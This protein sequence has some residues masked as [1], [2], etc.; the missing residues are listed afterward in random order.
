MSK[1]NPVAHAL[2]HPTRRRI[3]EAL[4]HSHGS[5]TAS[6]FHDD[7]MQ[8]ERVGLDQIIYHV[9]QLEKDGIVQF[10]DDQ[11]KGMQRRSFVLAGPHSS[12]AVRLL[13]LTPSKPH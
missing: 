8:D 2:N 5:L 11:D 1:R 10:G 4:W 12:E 3:T 9:R 13:G 7:Y 6:Q